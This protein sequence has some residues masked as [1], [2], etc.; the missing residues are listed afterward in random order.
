MKCRNVWASFALCA[1]FVVCA[2]AAEIGLVEEI[3]AK[4]N[5]DIITRSEIDKARRQTEAELKARGLSG[6]QLEAAVAER[7][8]DALRERIDQLLLVQ[9]GKELS[10]NVDPDVSKYVAELQVQSKIADPE[11]F[12]QYVREQTGQTY[13][14]FRSEVRNGYLNAARDPAGSR[15]PHQ[16]PSGGTR[17]ILQR[18]QSEVHA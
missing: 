16:R 2:P 14:D 15:Q 8:K 10:I 11:K 12:Q 5:G 17:E 18:E 1:S 7:D 4:V 3:V 6:P 13:E 9:K